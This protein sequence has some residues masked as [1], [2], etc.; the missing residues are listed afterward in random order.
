M[1]TITIVGV[2]KSY[3]NDEIL[4]NL[5]LTIPSGQFFALLGPSG[6]GKTTLLRLIAGFEEVD[7]GK[8]YIG[9]KDITHTPINERKVNTVF[10]QYALF[11]HLNVF[12]NVAYGLRIKKLPI[13][14][15]E[16][17]VHK[18]LKVVGL[19][20]QMYKAINQLSGGQKQRVALARAVV[21]EPDVLLLDEPLA[22][23]D[24][25]LREKMLV[26]LIELQDTLK[27]TFVYITH[28]Q[29]EALTV[30]DTMA[31]MNQD[32]QIEQ[33]GTPKEIYEFPVSSFVAQFV[34]STNI[35]S[36]TLV[37]H[38]TE[39]L[40][41][42][43]YLGKIPVILPKERAAWMVEGA[44][45]FLSIRPE[46][47]HISKTELTD[48]SNMLQGMVTSI[49]YYGR[50]TQYNVLLKNDLTV[51]VFTLNDKHITTQE[52]DYDDQVYIYWQKENAVLLKE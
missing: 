4:Q 38:E 27:T 42:V 35:L 3:H 21:N 8:I 49:I 17:K 22:A 30:A 50:S 39:E 46:K 31:I 48:F 14:V 43:P 25:N 11:P 18:M 6:S 33:V 47:L 32:G 2:C 19:E 37:L 20:K 1:R 28:D 24:Q 41:D 23:L 52:I 7:A 45:V 13:D 26:E 40:L 5:N 29:A 10:Q 51:E 15:I 16:Q 36:G 44:Q 34:G 12:D 9:N